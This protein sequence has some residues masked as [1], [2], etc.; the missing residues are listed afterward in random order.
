MLY[1]FSASRGVQV[2]GVA[3]VAGGGVTVVIA[4]LLLEIR[5]EC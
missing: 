1:S 3:G 5:P 4:V 2:A